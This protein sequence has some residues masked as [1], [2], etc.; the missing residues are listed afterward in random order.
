M[1]FTAL[2]SLNVVV[3]AGRGVSVSAEQRGDVLDVLVAFV[4][5]GIVYLLLISPYFVRDSLISRFK[6]YRCVY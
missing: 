1:L 6:P 3:A 2:P 5:K 4:T